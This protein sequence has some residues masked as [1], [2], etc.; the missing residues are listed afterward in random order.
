MKHFNFKHGQSGN[1][2]HPSKI[3]LIWNAMKQ[4]CLNKNTYAYKYYGGHGITV[5]KEWLNFINFYKDMGDKPPGL[6][7]D[8]IDN[9]KGYFKE[10]CRWAT[11][12]QQ[13][14]NQG[15]YHINKPK[16]EKIIRPN[17][18]N[19]NIPIE[20]CEKEEIYFL[21]CQNCTLQAIGDWIGLSKSRIRQ[22]L[23]KLNYY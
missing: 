5:C 23:I 20:F 7:I 13:N 1:G 17:P 22:I 11:Y 2:K 14:N 18:R 10:N 15:K 19:I 12:R 4:R 21:K 9:N 6:T 8:R 16:R 3:Y